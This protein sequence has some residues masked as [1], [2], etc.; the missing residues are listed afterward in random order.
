MDQIVYGY[1]AVLSLAV[2]GAVLIALIKVAGCF[3][4]IYAILYLV[5]ALFLGCRCCGGSRKR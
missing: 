1:L 3:V 5:R 4:L 2:L